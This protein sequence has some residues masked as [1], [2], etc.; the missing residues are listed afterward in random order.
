ME[1]TTPATTTETFVYLADHINQNGI[2]YGAKKLELMRKACSLRNVPINNVGEEGETLDPLFRVKLFD[3]CGS[4]S[5][6]IQEYDPASDIAFG[7]VEG[8]ETELGSFSLT[9]LSEIKGRMGI[10]IE[11]DTHFSPKTREELED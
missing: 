8:H 11:V 7:L 5:W 4:W 6:Y 3:P 2:T 9:E 1:T 10:G